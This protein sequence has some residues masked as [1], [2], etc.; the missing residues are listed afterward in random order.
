MQNISVSELKKVLDV[1]GDHVVVDVRP[2]ER[3]AAGH[4]PRALNIP[5][6]KIEKEGDKF[7]G[8]SKVYIYCNSGNTS[9]LAC[10]LLESMGCENAIN[11]EGGIIEWE[12]LGFKTERS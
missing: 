9:Q 2:P 12:R 8:N 4:I 10:M 3:Y 1:S 11:V 6:E 5:L 7:L